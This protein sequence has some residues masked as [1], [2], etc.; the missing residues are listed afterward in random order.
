MADTARTHAALVALLA[1]NT[2]GNISPQDLRDMLESLNSPMGEISYFNVTGTAVTINAQSNGSTNMVVCN[3]VTSVKG[4]GYLFDNGGANNGRLRYIGAGDKMLHVACSI[5]FSGIGANE[6]F[7]IGVAKNGTVDAA[8]KCIRKVGGGGDIGSTAMHLMTN[9]S[10][11]DYLEVYVGNM[12]STA[13]F[14]VHALN[15]F[16]AGMMPQS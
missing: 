16:A 6:N 1:D 3:P 11:N 8:S 13:N 4:G 5:S 10:Q 15:I 2:T 7:V 12:S 14:T 9:V